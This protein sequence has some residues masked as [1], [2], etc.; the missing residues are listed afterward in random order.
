MDNLYNC[1]SDPNPIKVNTDAECVEMLTSLMVELPLNDMEKEL[2]RSCL[3]VVMAKPDDDLKFGPCD[4]IE[5]S[6]LAKNHSSR[7]NG[8]QACSY[9]IYNSI[10]IVNNLTDNDMAILNSTIMSLV[11][12]TYEIFNKNEDFES[13]DVTYTGKEVDESINNENQEY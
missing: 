4:L 5:L 8:I 1:Y 6:L 13:D 12:S 2:I 10:D 7:A 9:H 11:N 3:N